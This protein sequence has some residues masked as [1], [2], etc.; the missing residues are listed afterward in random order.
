MQIGLDKH[1][2]ES[3]ETLRD[4]SQRYAIKLNKLYKLNGWYKGYNPK[5]G[6]CIKLRK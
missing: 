1:V 4:I 5:E 6:D 2:V 3:G